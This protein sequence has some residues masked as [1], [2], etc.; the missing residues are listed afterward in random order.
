M[1]LLAINNYF[2]D[3][4]MIKRF[5]SHPVIKAGEIMFQERI[6]DNIVITKEYKEILKIRETKG[7]I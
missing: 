7:Y 3:D 5:H 4:I 6:K 1:S 2:N